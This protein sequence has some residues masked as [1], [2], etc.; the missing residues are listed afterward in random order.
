MNL[1]FVF[2]LI[3]LVAIV[4]RQNFSLSLLFLFACV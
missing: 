1:V 4:D 2:F 3:F